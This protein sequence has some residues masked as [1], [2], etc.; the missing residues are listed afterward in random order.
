MD[1]AILSVL[2]LFGIFFFLLAIGVPISISIG[3]SSIVSVMVATPLD[4][5][6]YTSA[7]RLFSGMNSFALL[8][9]V[10]FIMSGS[11]MNNGGIALR[12]INLAKLIAGRLPGSLAHT[13]VVGNMLFGSISGSAVASAA[14]IGSVMAPLQ[15]KE[16]YD[17]GFSA[18]VNI[19]S[20]PVGILIP[21]SGVLILYS[22]V[23]GGTSVSALFMAG[24][25]PG[26]L[27]GL[28]VMIVAYFIAKKNHYTISE[29]IGL[30]EAN[31]IIIQSIPSLLL[32][33]IVI[34]GIVAGIFTATEGAAV[35]V[36]YSLILSLIYRSLTWAHIPKIFKETIV[37]TGIVLF[38]VA[39]S[40]IMSWAMALTGMPAA[41][42]NGL[43]SISDNRYIVL[44]IMMLILLVV[45]IF[46]DLTPAV[47]IFTP[48]FLPIV[49]QMGVDP[50]H[51][52][53]MLV[54]NLAIGA[55]TPPVGSVLF[56]GCSVGKVSIEEVI[57]PLS[58]FFIALVAALFIVVYIPSISL[59]IP[60][61][62]NLL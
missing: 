26:I 35:A 22:L 6:L 47:L 51:F 14:A 41:I 55:M 38:L 9:I 7:Q 23:S 27:M 43:L 21:P 8:A 4:V 10:F 18:A 30:K 19:T 46:M 34:G 15:K 39:V 33:V 25:L 44:L 50:V 29:K 48:I 49:V 28:T 3:L 16:G 11:I 52:G 40:S 36:L 54:F 37:M 31:R 53:I 17:K 61:L 60:K 57:K 13:N 1:I 42:S 12:L 2:L 59:I 45:G 5:I 20:S 32:I 56:I 24:Y 58:Y 62:F